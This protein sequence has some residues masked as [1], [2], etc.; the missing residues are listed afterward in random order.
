M[1]NNNE[2]YVALETIGELFL[3]PGGG[4]THMYHGKRIEP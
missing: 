3:G 2:K 4:D 1:G